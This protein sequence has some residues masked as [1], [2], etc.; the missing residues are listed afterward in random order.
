M[1][2][3]GGGARDRSQ[4]SMDVCEVGIGDNFAG[5]WRHAAGRVA[6]VGDQSGNGNRVGREL[7]ARRAALTL[8]AVA[9]VATEL[10]EEMLAVLGIAFCQG[11]GDQQERQG[12]GA[13]KR[14]TNRTQAGRPVLQ[15]AMRFE[16]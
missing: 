2:F 8:I 3:A 6:D 5:E 11:G 7:G 15:D 10:G 4:E 14:G 9:G 12:C 16:S 13:R 1:F